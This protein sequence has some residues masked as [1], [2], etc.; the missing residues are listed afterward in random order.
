MN[1][2]QAFCYMKKKDPVRS[3][4]INFYSASINITG[5]TPASV[6][7]FIPELII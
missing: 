3:F 5:R 6:V 2:S 1:K 4:L 7:A